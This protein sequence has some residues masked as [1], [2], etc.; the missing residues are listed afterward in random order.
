MTAREIIKK[1]INFDN[2]SRIGYDFQYGNYSDFAGINL[3]MKDDE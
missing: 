2:P 3:K 1:V